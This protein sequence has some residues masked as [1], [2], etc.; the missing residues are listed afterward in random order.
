MSELRYVIRPAESSGKRHWEIFDNAAQETIG[1]FKE[2]TGQM[3]RSTRVFADEMVSRLNT[4]SDA[5]IA[6]DMARRQLSGAVAE[7]TDEQAVEQIQNAQKG[8]GVYLTLE[9]GQK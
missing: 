2:G 3:A 7:L 4:E 5:M 8:H 9:S 1:S 6:G